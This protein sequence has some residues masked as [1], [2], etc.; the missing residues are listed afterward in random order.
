MGQFDTDP[1]SSSIW[2]N[3][4]CLKWTC[5]RYEWVVENEIVQ[6]F[7]MGHLM[8]RG[9]LSMIFIHNFHNIG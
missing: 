1:G 2:H 8:K 5:L 7:W 6:E 9:F 4:L 3:R